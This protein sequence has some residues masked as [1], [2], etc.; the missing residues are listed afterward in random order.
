MTD[1]EEPSDRGPAWWT[2]LAELCAVAAAFTGLTLWEL[3]PIAR[4]FSTHLAPD[5]GDALFNVYVLEWVK[6]QL[7]LGL[8][9]LWN[10]NIF[11]PSRGVLA[12]SDHLLALAAQGWLL[13]PFVSTPVAGYNALL[14]LAFVGTGTAT[15]GVARRC[16]CAPWGAALAA[17]GFTLSP[18]RWHNLNH[19]Q[20]LSVQWV[21]LVLWCA[22]RLLARPSW[23]RG[24]AFLLVYL[25]NLAGGSYVAYMTHVPLAVLVAAHFLRDRRALLDRR[26]WRVAGPLLAVVAAAGIWLYAPYVRVASTLGFTRDPEEIETH[27][28]TAASY[29]SPA[30]GAGWLPWTVREM[31]GRHETPW[32]RVENRLYPGAVLSL[33]AL[34]GV[35][36]WRRRRPG[37][38]RFR[39]SPTERTLAIAG[40]AAGLA[41][42][43]WSDVRTLA[44]ARLAAPPAALIDAPWRAVE[45]LFAI[46][47]V[48]WTASWIL[49]WRR[50]RSYADPG[51][52]SPQVVA[53]TW[54][55]AVFAWGVVCVLLSSAVVFLATAAVLPGLSGMRVPARFYVFVS[56][57][58]ALFAGLGLDRLVSRLGSRWQR[59]AAAAALLALAVWELS[60]RPFTFARVPAPGE[61]SPVYAWIAATPD[62]RA[63]LEL[64]VRPNVRE[65]Q[66]L[67]AATV[68]WKPIANGYSGFHPEPFRRIVAA[69]PTLPDDAGFALLRELGITHLVVHAGDRRMRVDDG[70]AALR[71]WRERREGHDVALAF[72]SANDLVFRVLPSHV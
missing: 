59:G 44:A 7:A 15:Y 2:F 32:T 8:P 4:L 37:V 29:L 55:N 12:L 9:D 60:P 40:A 30:E 38:P 27:G 57:A 49:H 21:P 22:H 69:I 43:T 45:G 53:A 56:L 3:R 48:L 31:H 17:V 35:L 65:T 34:G 70:E 68:H 18:F 64:P 47:G 36:A 66:Y 33:L 41:A 51:R 63:V 54:W 50:T 19:L 10:P 23:R 67:Y 58:V 52:A 39:W 42:L 20:M 28:A 24:A 1:G 5:A 6:R 62:V 46:G 11:F 61:L 25:P 72:T 13:Q 26:L 16:G 14:L 71:A